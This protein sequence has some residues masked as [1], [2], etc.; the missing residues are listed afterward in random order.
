MSHRDSPQ[1]P[2]ECHKSPD[3][4]HGR[5]TGS[6]RP[7][8]KVAKSPEKEKITSKRSRSEDT[9]EAI[10]NFSPEKKHRQEK[11]LVIYD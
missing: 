9:Q 11:E 1:F 8:K 2:Q 10:E 5:K 4:S 6:E 3:D 7:Q